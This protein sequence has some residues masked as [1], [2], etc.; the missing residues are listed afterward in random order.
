MN[1]IPELVPC[2]FCGEIPGTTIR[3]GDECDNPMYVFKIT[4]SCGGFDGSHIS[5]FFQNK[6]SRKSCLET[7]RQSVDVYSKEWNHRHKK[8]ANVE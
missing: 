6:S 4:H 7:L 3:E 5:L 8:E 2:R 1:K